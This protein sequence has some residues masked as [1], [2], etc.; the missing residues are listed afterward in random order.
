M[1]A[2]HRGGHSAGRFRQLV[3]NPCSEET[4]PSIQ[5]K[6]GFAETQEAETAETLTYGVAYDERPNE[7]ARPQG[8]P[9]CRP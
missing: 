4:V 3:G 8:G 5:G 7:D 6:M 1:D 9:H 2:H